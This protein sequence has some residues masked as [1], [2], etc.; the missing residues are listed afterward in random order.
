MVCGSGVLAAIRAG[1]GAPAVD[2]FNLVILL[3]TPDCFPSP[4]MSPG[5][6]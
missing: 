2:S 1:D 4:T 6:P 3:V 5:S